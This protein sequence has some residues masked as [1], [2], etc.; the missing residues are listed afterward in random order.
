[1]TDSEEKRIYSESE[2]HDIN[3]FPLPRA[4]HG[5]NRGGLFS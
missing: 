4:G 1:M 2:I 3:D 5:A